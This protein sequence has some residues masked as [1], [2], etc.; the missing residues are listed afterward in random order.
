MDLLPKNHKQFQSPEYWNA[1][2]KDTQAKS[3][4]EWYADYE[5]LKPHLT[6]LIKKPETDSVLV[7]GCG[8]SVLSEKLYTNMQC[9]KV[10]SIDFEEQV[11]KDM[12]E[13]ST[14]PVEY[15]VMDMLDMSGF[16]NGT[17]DF[18]IDKGSL[19]ALCSDSSPETLAKVIKYF[20]EV[21]RVLKPNGGQYMCVSLLQDFILEA[22]IDFFS[23]G[24]QNG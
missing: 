18:A 13:K 6:K 3:G 4:F 19:D 9:Q 17:F 21:H 15:K 22:L 24:K 23:Q 8:N 1:F 5:E 10:T 12:Q 7:V 14:S 16:E 20:T 2:F 11:I